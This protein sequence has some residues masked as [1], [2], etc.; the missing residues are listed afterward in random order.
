MGRA[1]DVASLEGLEGLTIGR[2]AGDLGMSKAGVIGHF[3]SKELLQLAAVEAAGETFTREVW[4]PA[5][6]ERPGLRRLLAIC[7]A[8][9]DHISSGSFPGGCF[10]TGASTEFDGRAG[11]V[12]D[13]IASGLAQWHDRLKR[14]ASIAID[15]GELP[16]DPDAAQIGFELRS[17][18]MGLNQELQLHG[19]PS[20]PDHA[21]RAVRRVLGLPAGARP[22][23]LGV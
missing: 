21:R 14:E 20:A 22:A 6:D 1:V 12:R 23:K 11:P 16:P 9:I 18:A 2:L 3:G 4:M 19:D 17:I 7:D 8:W 10:W 5:R 13:A 15:N